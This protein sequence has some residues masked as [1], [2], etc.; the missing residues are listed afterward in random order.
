[1]P[2]AAL[3]L[4]AWAA[5][6]RPCPCTSLVPPN[7]IA[8]AP[9]NQVAVPPAAMSSCWAAAMCPC[10]CMSLAPANQ[11]AE[12]ATAS[13]LDHAASL[14]QLKVADDIGRSQGT[15]ST[16]TMQL[17]ATDMNTAQQRDFTHFHPAV[18]RSMVYQQD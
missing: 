7:H 17:R 12:N 15:V 1:M 3:S 14:N 9:A 11:E 8:L 18:G 5:A 4:E 10:P 6:K 2:L 13:Q 16:A